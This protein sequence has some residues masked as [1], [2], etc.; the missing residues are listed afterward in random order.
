MEAKGFSLLSHMYTQ[1][2]VSTKD[3]LKTSLFGRLRCGFQAKERKQELLR[4]REDLKQAEGNLNSISI[5]IAC[6]CL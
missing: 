2:Y 1:S 3:H 4:L 6:V 5:R